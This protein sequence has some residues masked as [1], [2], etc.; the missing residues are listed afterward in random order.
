[1]RKLLVIAGILFSCNQYGQDFV[2]EHFSSNDGLSNN[3]VRDILQDQEGYLW[4]ATSGGLNRFDGHFFEVYKPVLG[5][6]SSLSDSRLTELSQDRYGYIWVW[7]SL[8]NYH[9]IDP[10]TRRVTNLKE[11]GV[12]PSGATVNDHVFAGD[13]NIWLILNSGVMRLKSKPGTQEMYYEYYTEDDYLSDNTVNFVC[14]DDSNRVWIG[15][16]RGLNKF[17]FDKNDSLVQTVS[18]FTDTNTGFLSYIKLYD[19]IIFSTSSRELYIFNYASATLYMDEKISPLLK[20]NVS[21]AEE[22]RDGGLLFGTDRGDV[23]FHDPASGESVYFESLKTPSLDAGL[24]SEIFADSYS[25]F[26]FITDKRGVYQFNPFTRKF[27]YFDL[28]SENRN[29]LGEDDKQI[30]LEDSNRNL[31][32]GINGGGL[33]LLNRKDNAF[34]QFKHDPKN[35]SSISSDIVLSLYEDRSKNLWIGT[36]YG[37]INKVSLKK[38]QFRRISPETEPETGFDNYVR[39]VVTDPLGNIWVG[40]KAGKIYVYR[41]GRKIGTIPDDLHNPEKFPPTNVYCLYF[42]NDHNLWVG[43]KGY[44]I[45]IF[46]S[47]L[48]YFS[49]L[50]HRNIE[51][52]HLRSSPGIQNSLSSDN[53]YSIVQDFHG[54]YWIGNFI[55]G[56]DLLTDPFGTPRYRN[57][58]SNARDESGIVSEEVRHLFLDKEHN[59]WIATSDGISILESRYLQAENKRFLN[60]YPSLSDT[61]NLSGKVVYQIMQAQNNDIYAAML[62]GGINQLKA[63]DLENRN[64]NWIHHTSPILSPNV[65]CIEE[66]NCGNIWMGTDNGLFKLRMK[67]DIIE[68]YRIRNSFMPLIFSEST[69]DRTSR[70]ELVFGTNDGFIVFHPDSI[71]KDS[72]QYPLIFSRLEINGELIGNSNTGILKGSIDKANNIELDH[73]QNNIVLYFSVLDFDKPD[74]IQYTYYLDGYDNYWSKPSTDNMANYRK[75]PPGNYTLYVK[76]TNSSG[77]WIN[78]QARLSLKINPPFWKSTRGFILIFL[79]ISL[80]VTAALIIIYRQIFL[81]NRLKVENAITEKRIEYYTNISH[82]FKTPLSLILNPVEEIIMSHKSSEFARQKGVQIK[83]NATYLKRLIDQILD[84][85]KLREGKMQ[86]RV[87]EINLIDF[88]REVY[89]LFLPLSNKIGIKFDFD[90]N[91]DE[92]NGYADARQLEKVTINLLS[93][94]FR[95]TPSGKSVKLIVTA[96]E[97]AGIIEFLVEDEGPGIDEDEIPKIFDRFYLSKGSTGIGLF[98]TKELVFLHKGEIE[99]FNNANG[100]ASFRIMIPVNRSVYSHDEVDESHAVKGVLDVTSINDIETIISTNPTTETIHKHVANYM[101]TILVIE[102]NDELRKYLCSELSKKYRVLE[103]GDGETGLELAIEH[104]PEL[105]LCDVVI[106]NINGYAF[107]KTLKENY[108]TS[109]IPIFLLTAEASEEKKLIGAESGADDYIVK[110]FNMGYLLTKIEK[111]IYQR[112]KLRKRYENE[113]DQVPEKEAT[114]KSSDSDFMTE[115]QEIV[116]QNLSNHELNVEFLVEKMGISRTLFFKKI[117]SSSGFSPNEFLRLI[118]MKEAAKLLTSTDKTVNEIGF[119]IGFNDSN[120]FGKT[121]KKHFGMTPSFYRSNNSRRSYL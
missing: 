61:T 69:S 78:K 20:G 119:S 17:I 32:V 54:Q 48:G 112:K 62:E 73:T 76:G 71:H 114:A 117:K 12:L 31:W 67:D 45:Y 10:D 11:M 36:S 16:N 109:H 110:P 99:V 106:P 98:F 22:N 8:G 108:L 2:F 93:N 38:D 56:V 49:N 111:T 107:T 39:S 88:F 33:F 60:L 81:Q 95:F 7:S 28:N 74:A 85:R 59:L 115:V 120:Y 65:Y 121:F 29:F 64:F 70:H 5:D 87:A 43:T 55:G 46:K 83:K 6:T 72:S 113:T 41:E 86:L 25:I 47:I 51:V 30:L 90:S 102:D 116:N 35:N 104:L 118:R 68:K 9:R 84:F 3:L 96:D 19:R 82:E 23:V 40:S 92:F 100:G 53:I 21:V 15:T 52:I 66:D 57:Y 77:A 79:I 27:T 105:I 18:F 89:L 34:K 44:G 101:E 26:W 1:M 37:G 24:I 75:L 97:P 50:Q 14:P 42:D 63:E 103:S 94:A 4:F 80:L 13:G 91:L 58:N